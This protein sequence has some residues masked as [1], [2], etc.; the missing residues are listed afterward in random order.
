MKA[1]VSATLSVRLGAEWNENF[2]NH[3]L[4]PLFCCLSVRSNC[5]IE[6]FN[7][8]FRYRSGASIFAQSR[9]DLDGSFGRSLRKLLCVLMRRMAEEESDSSGPDVM[10]RVWQA[11]PGQS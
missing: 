7:G 8:C 5:S 2:R 11:L 1:R 4:L 10:E 9:R 3:H 6:R